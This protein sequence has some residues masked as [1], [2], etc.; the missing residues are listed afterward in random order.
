MSNA[1]MPALV[2][3]STLKQTAV[4]LTAALL[5]GACNLSVDNTAPKKEEEK[6]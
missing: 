3:R 1:I 6:T 5:L 4:A 2:R